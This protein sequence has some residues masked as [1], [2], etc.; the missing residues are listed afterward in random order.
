MFTYRQ[1]TTVCISH[2]AWYTCISDTLCDS[3]VLYQ[4]KNYIGILNIELLY[5]FVASFFVFVCAFY[6]RVIVLHAV[7]LITFNQHYFYFIL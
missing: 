3:K 2:I 1:E 7:L 5:M 4:K 6:T